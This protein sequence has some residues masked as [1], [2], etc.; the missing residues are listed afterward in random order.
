MPDSDATA[1]NGASTPSGRRA[2]LASWVRE[3][4]E[5]WLFVGSYL[6]LAILLS[7]LISFFWLAVIVG[8]HFAF[9]LVRQSARFT[10]RKDV[11]VEAL[12]EVK[13]DIVLVVLA[14]VIGVYMDFVLGVLGL[15]SVGQLGTAV[16]AGSRVPALQSAIRGILLSVDEAL[17]VARSLIA[18]RKR[19]S[20]RTE[21]TATPEERRTHASGELSIRKPWN[22]GDWFTLALLAACLLLLVLAPNF[23][24]REW[25]D[26]LAIMGHEM[27]PWP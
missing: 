25:P 23:T 15:R 5:S 10:S 21:A 24:G 20:P 7:L 6:I 27:H 13:L 1:I 26:V 9:E 16:R 12:W 17:Q 11:A 8:V 18:R 3:H 2:A 19:G 22:M 14:V 4:D